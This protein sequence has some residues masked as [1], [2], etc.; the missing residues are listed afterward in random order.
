VRIMANSMDNVFTNNNFTG[1][2]FDVTTNSRQNFNTFT[3]NYWSSYRG[4]DLDRDGVG[5]VPHHPVRLFALLTEKQPP[6]L[7]L[8]NSLFVR[9]IDTTE[10]VMP[11]FTPETLVDDHPL[12]RAVNIH[13]S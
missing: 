13:D 1:N 2:V 12:T 4:Y 8:M 11:V 10:R 6:A 7:V 5:D 9:I 3:S